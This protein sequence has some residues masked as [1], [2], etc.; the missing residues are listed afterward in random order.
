MEEL[1]ATQEEAA[2]KTAE[3]ESLIGA[4]HASSFVIEYD[5]NGNI[6]SVNQAYL[7]L[8][9]QSENEVIGTHHSDN[10]EMTDEQ[11]KNYQKFWNDLR[12]GMVKKE[13]SRIKL[14]KKTLTFIE[15]YS[16]I[17]NQNRQVV[18]ILKI[19]H[20]ITDFIEDEKVKG[21]KTK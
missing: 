13:T 16:P 5:L 12:N 17:F 1:Q 4:L 15:T 9:G 19:A 10:L 11:K 2:R 3:M 8:T 6:T 20:N 18:K 7:T 14:G 21:R